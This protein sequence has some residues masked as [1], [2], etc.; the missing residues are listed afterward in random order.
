MKLKKPL[1]LLLCGI[2]ALSLGAC[3][4]KDKQETPT[5]NTASQTNEQKVLTMAVSAE[6]NTLYP[7]NMDVQNNVATKLCYEG[8]VNYVDG[9]VEP[10]LAEKWEF[11]N[12]GKDLTFYLKKGVK[13]HDGT[14]FNAQAVK[15]CFEFAKG[16]PNFGAIRAACNLESVEV[17]DDH[18]VT[19]HYPNAYFAY[20][21]DFCYPE[22]MILESPKVILPEGDENRYMTMSGVVGTGPYIYDE[23]VEGDYVRFVRNNNYWG[24]QPYYEEVIVK[25]IPE[26]S[27]RLQ[28]LQNGEI[29]MIYGSALMTWDDYEQATSLPNIKGIVSSYN[30]NTRNIILNAA[31]PIL[32][33]IKVREA[34]AYAIDKEA[35]SSGL[36]FGNEVAATK[37]FPE[38]TPYTDTQLNV[39]RTFDKEKAESLLDQAGWK[40]NE[41]T[42]IREKE[43]EPLNI[44]FTYDSGNAMNHD[45]A[46]VILSQL[47]E[48]GI[49]VTTTGQDMM[50]WWKEGASGHYDITIWNTEQPYTSPHNY[51]APML[52]RSAH[53]P[54]LAGLG[55]ISQFTSYINEF[56]TTDD[57]TRIKEIFDYLLN[58]DND[59]VIDVPL[60]YVKDMIVFN[61]D[62]ISDYTFTSTPM[63][64]DIRQITP[65]EQKE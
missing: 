34:I 63:F 40:M 12:D 9:K 52:N 59:N 42:G 33:D 35:I 14:D 26:P 45:L 54:S 2:M 38:G 29:D 60:L 24:D 5:E 65:A 62:K 31:S 7:L 21:Y 36:T 1:S 55:D 11:T 23:I 22:V 64:F 56:Q 4:S 46:T 32:K 39:T 58:F 44:T 19:F 57:E 37:L 61:S 10:C 47:A 15:E 18:T 8:L 30:S 13:Y 16:N 6:L 48:V 28:A 51:F 3:S 49:N 50:T 20:L 17:I 41:T 25:Y 27:A 53:A 43:G